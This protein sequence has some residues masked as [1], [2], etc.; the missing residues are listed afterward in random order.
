MIFNGLNNTE[1]TYCYPSASLPSKHIADNAKTE[2]IK[3]VIKQLNGRPL[4]LGQGP[5]FLLS[6][7]EIFAE[8]LN[9]VKLPELPE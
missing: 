6:V 3:Q 4:Y 7:K 8:N 5:Y 9:H 1:K 2:L